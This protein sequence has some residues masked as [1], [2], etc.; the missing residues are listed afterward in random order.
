MTPITTSVPAKPWHKSKT[1]WANVIVVVTAI[2][3][4]IHQ[5]LPDLVGQFAPEDYALLLFITGALNIFLRSI[6]NSG[7]IK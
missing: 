5:F 2:A 7:I 6:T 3:G 1:I 4:A